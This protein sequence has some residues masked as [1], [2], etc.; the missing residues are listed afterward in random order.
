MR[1]RIVLIGL[2]VAVVT[3]VVAVA[4]AADSSM[5]DK[6]RFTGWMAPS[7]VSSPRHVTVDGDAPVLRFADSWNLTE[8]P[9]A[10]RVCVVK[11]GTSRR[12]C[13]TGRARIDT[14]D[15]TL[16]INVRCCGQFLATWYVRGR[17]VAQWPFLYNPERS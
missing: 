9:T 12:S 5:P 15:S 8:T 4:F 6:Y 11:V 1:Y 17:A 10:Y 13:R 7:A 16:P 2:I 14:R 3:A